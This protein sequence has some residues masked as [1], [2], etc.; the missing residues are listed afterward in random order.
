MATRTKPAPTSKA[1][2]TTGAAPSTKA[3]SGTGRTGTQAAPAAPK[4]KR[5]VWDY[6]R[7]NP[8]QDKAKRSI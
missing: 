1:A 3:R 6:I 5:R 7:K 8:L 2:S 4:D